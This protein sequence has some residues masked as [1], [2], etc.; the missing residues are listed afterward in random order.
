M[1]CPQAFIRPL[2][3]KLQKASHYQ[4][5]GLQKRLIYFV[6]R[7]VTSNEGIELTHQLTYKQAAPLDRLVTKGR[8][9]PSIIQEADILISRLRGILPPHLRTRYSE[10]SI[11]CYCYH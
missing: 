3:I 9:H 2:M 4:Y 8:D 1:Q 11:S 10:L 7:T 5:R 6:C